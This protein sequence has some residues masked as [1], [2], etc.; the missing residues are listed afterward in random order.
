MVATVEH[1]YGGA[2][3]VPELV[4]WPTDDG[5]C[6]TAR[7]TCTFARGTGRVPR[8]TQVSSPQHNGMA[9]AFVHTLER[10]RV[11]VNSRPGAQTVIAAANLD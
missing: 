11:R 1:R 6:C 4:E 10:D 7:D 9:E 8:T 2:I 5:C 3:R